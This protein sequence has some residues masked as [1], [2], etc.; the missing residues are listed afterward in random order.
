[1]LRFPL[2][3]TYKS[4]QIINITFAIASVIKNGCRWHAWQYRINIYNV[5]IQITDFREAF[6][7]VKDGRQTAWRAG[8]GTPLSQERSKHLQT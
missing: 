4:A 2:H 5:Y 3:L 1:M 7:T 6:Y 8:T